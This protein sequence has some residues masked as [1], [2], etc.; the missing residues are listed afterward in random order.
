MPEEIKLPVSQRIKLMKNIFKKS[1]LLLQLGIDQ[2]IKSC[3]RR[4]IYAND[5]LK[6][7]IGD[8]GRKWKLVRVSAPIRINTIEGEA[9]GTIGN[10]FV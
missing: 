4:R 7:K 2:T 9:V 6:L 10:N 5:C 3:T 8:K 1:K